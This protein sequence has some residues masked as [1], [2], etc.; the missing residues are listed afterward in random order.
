[1]AGVLLE[2]NPCKG[3]D[4]WRGWGDG[5]GALAPLGIY[6][7]ICGGGGGKENWRRSS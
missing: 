1:M 3:V 2:H 5:W 6:V 7:C 4:N